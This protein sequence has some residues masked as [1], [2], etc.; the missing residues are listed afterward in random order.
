MGSTLHS[1]H[2]GGAM[3]Q[4]L[5]TQ[6]IRGGGPGSFQPQLD[7]LMLWQLDD[8]P[9]WRGGFG[10]NCAC[11]L[12]VVRMNGGVGVRRSQGWA[13]VLPGGPDAK[14]CRTKLLNG[15]LGLFLY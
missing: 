8:Q 2:G 13:D 10:D 12:S 11:P 14:S 15:L 7:T 9:R 1:E 4:R 6:A 5:Q 3:G